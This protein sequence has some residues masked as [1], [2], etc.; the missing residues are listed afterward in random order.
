[1]TKI[2]LIL[3]EL[4]IGKVLLARLQMAQIRPQNLRYKKI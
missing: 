4:Q 3:M 1:M 2:R